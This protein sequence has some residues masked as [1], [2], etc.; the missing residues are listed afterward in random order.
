M[1]RRVRVRFN[2]GLGRCRKL[3][4]NVPL[5]YGVVIL[6]LQQPKPDIRFYSLTLFHIFLIC[7]RLKYG[8]NQR[9][10]TSIPLK[11]NIVFWKTY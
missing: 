1:I 5:R 8:F 6:F 10:I 3:T 9:F 7:H 2:F 11:T 4:V